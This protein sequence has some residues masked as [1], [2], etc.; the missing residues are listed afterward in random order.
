MAFDL[1]ALGRVQLTDRGQAMLD[2]E[3][4]VAPCGT[5]QAGYLLCGFRK[6]LGNQAKKIAF[7]PP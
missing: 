3:I 2:D 7:V 6:I 4:H 5:Q 1:P